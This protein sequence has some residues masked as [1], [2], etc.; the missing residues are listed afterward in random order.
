MPEFRV[1]SLSIV[2]QIKSNL[3]DRY[4]SG[5]PVLKEL[6]QNADDAGARR[7]RLDALAGWPNAANPLLR[8]PGLLVVNDGEFREDDE[9]GITSFGESGKV[10]DSA[11]I[12]KFG[13]GQ[14]AVFHLCD[15]F[16]VYAHGDNAP[17]ST[18]VNPFLGVDVD[19]NISRQWEPPSDGNLVDTDLTLLKQEISS[20]FP[21]RCLALWL[22]FRREGLR[23]APEAGFSSNFPSVSETIAE[24]ANPDDLRVLLTALRHLE[25]IEIREHGE[26]RCAIGLDDISE[27]LLGPKHWQSGTRSF[28][29]TIK[30][31]SDQSVAQFVG[32]ET[33]A[34]D[35][36]LAGLRQTPHWPKTISVLSPTPQ[37]EKGEPHGAATLLR[38]SEGTLSQLRISWAVFLPISEDY[39]TTIPLDGNSLGQFRLLLHGY[40]FLDSGRRQI[41]GLAASAQA[42]EP[43]DASGLR[44]A[45]NTELR[46]SVVLPL[47]PALLRD[48]L[49][50]K[51]VTSAELGQLVAAVAESLWFQENRNAICKESALVRVLEASSGVIWRL[52]P[53]E[54][55][56]RPLPASV[57][58]APRKVEELF[59]SI[60]SWAGAK[61]AHLV[62]D[63]NAAL[64]AEPMVW[65]ADDLGALFAGL[66]TRAFQSRDLARLLADF[67]GAA[68]LGDAESA[69]VGT[70]L[71]AALRKAMIEPQ[72]LAS[73]ELVKSIL[74]HVPPGTLFPLPA[75]VE[76]RRVLRALASA[77]TNIL[78]TRSELLDESLGPPL[79]SNEDLK[80]LLTALSPLVGGEDHSDQAATAALALLTQAGQSISEL[81]TDPGLASI[82]VLRARDV[83]INGPVVLS[84][85]MLVAQS[86]DGL[87]FANSP[88]ANSLLPLLADTIPDATPVV[89]EGKTAE[90]LRDS[91][92]SSVRLHGVG[93]ESILAL[94]N[95][96]K[97]YGTKD[98]RRKLLER[99]RPT[100][101]DDRAALRRLCVG[102]S[103]AGYNSAV[104]HVLEGVPKGLERVVEAI[105]NSNPNAFLVP[106]DIAD[107]L[108]P[109][110][111][112]HIGITAL[113]TSGMTA[114]LERDV[115]VIASVQLTSLER[116]AF[117]LAQFPDS[118]LRSL[119]IHVRSDGTMSTAEN[120][121]READWPIPEELRPHVLT[122]QPCTNRQ[123]R[124]RQERLIEAWSPR[125]QIEV[126]LACTDPHRFRGAILDALAKLEA[127]P[128]EQ[129]LKSLSA[130][131][132]L[133]A[134]EQP[135][136]PQ[137]VLALPPAVDEPARALLLKS[138][139][140]PPFLPIAKL[141]IDVREHRGFG[142]L[143]K[144][145]L[146]DR[147][148]SFE[149][150]ALMIEDAKIIGRLGAANDYP[151]DDFATLAND[152]GDL[153]LPGWP[154]LAAVLTS[155]GDSRD[156]VEKIVAG[157]AGLDTSNAKLAGTHLGSLAALAEEKGRKGEAARRAYRHGF[158]VV[159]GWPE[160]ARRQVFRE[161]RV[162]TEAGSWHSG[163]EVVQGGD[164]LDPRHILARDYASML[165]KREHTEF[166]DAEDVPPD[167]FAANRHRGEVKE[168]DLVALETDSADQQKSF[169]DTWR[170][171]I[172]S[173]LVIVYLGLIGR[174]EPFRR[175]ANEW[176][177][178]AT[179]D[180]DTLW[181]EL[182]S[183]FPKEILYPNPLSVEVDQRRFLIEPVA[184]ERVQVIAMS[185]DSFDA[186]LGGPDK[187]I[188]IGNLHRTHEGIRT[189]DG[190][191]RS[192]ITLPVRQIDPSG[193]SH[194]EAN[195]IFRR[196]VETIATD[197]LWLGM[198]RQQTAL[199]GMLDKAVE[200]D[201]STIEETERLLRDRL[202]TI[203]A[204][205]K[206]PTEY[207][208]QKALREYQ[209]E[210]SRLHHLSA[211]AQKMEELKTEL[212][213]KVS[214]DALAI[215]LLSA[216]R[217]KIG[218]FGYSSSRVLF[219]L[220]QNADDAYRQHDGAA[221]DA[222]FRV[223][224]FSENSGGIR[225]IHWGRPINHLGR[226]AEEG[227]RL[228]HDRDLL[229]MLLMNF[230]EKRPGDD[231]TGKFGLGFKS[232]HALTD[233]VGI[234]SG[235]IA[236]RTVGGFLPSAWPEGISAGED[237]KSASGRKATVIEVP[238]STETAARGAEAV[239]A[240]RSAV[241][242]LPA[243]ARTIRRIE[244]EGADP[245]SVSCDFSPLLEESAIYVVSVSGR[246]RERALRFDLS[247]GYS[248]LLRI[249]AAG[250]CA[251]PNDLRR[252]WN[253][254]PLEEELRSGWLINGPFAVDPGR[255]GLAGSITDRQEWFRKLG[256]T[257]GDRLLM[258][259]DLANANWPQFA[260]SLDLD[261][262]R[263]TAWDIFWSRLFDVLEPD[264]DD[265]LGRYLHADGHGYSYLA[266]RHQVVPT[267]LPTPFA[268]LVR[269]SEAEYY[270]DGALSDPAT[271]GK[272]RDWPTLTELQSGIIASEI[273][274]QLR[275]L[276]FGTPRPLR[277][278]SLLRRQIGEEWR[279]DPDLAQV[280]GRAVTPQSIREAPLDGELHDI[281]DIARQA[282]FLAQDG[283]WR[284]AQL[285][286]PDAADDAEERRLCAFAPTK[287][288]L[289]KRYTGAA[290]EF[291]RVARERSGFG[292]QARDL[293]SWVA[294]TSPE[295]HNRQTAALRYVI[296]GRQGRELGEEIRRNRPSWLP[297]PAS[298]LRN[299]QLLSSWTEKEKDDLL[300]ALQGRDAFQPLPLTPSPPAKPET[301]LSAIYE[302]WSSEGTDLRSL[303]SE[304]TYPSTFSPSQLRETQD[305]TAW[306]TMFA[307]A[308]FQSF[309]RT[310][311]G[312]HRSFIEAAH[313]DGW[314]PELAGSRPPGDVQSWLERLE[315]W[316]APELFDQRYLVWRRTFVDLYAIARWLDEYR[317]ITLKLPR[318]IEDYDVISLNDALQP[319]YWAPAMALCI[320][321]A[322]INRSLGIGMNWMIRE[323]LREGVYEPQDEA[324]M[325]PY[326]WAPSQRV[327]EL[328]N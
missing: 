77:P 158:S 143:E 325:A 297:W 7:F 59:D 287:H 319:S 259:H 38:A 165:G 88:Q 258:L 54:N 206:L 277:F 20:D 268:S 317:E 166:A 84:L 293:G 178:D 28:G 91:P 41:E 135:V 92:N 64:S 192:L 249:D 196:F 310:Q 27:R 313:R 43:S 81:A 180:V 110:L 225:A 237:R 322:P 48:A 281:L 134:D 126:A 236:L 218:D 102:D 326:C 25:S 274:G 32:R 9:R 199:Q 67:L 55:T 113:D 6:L 122:I 214:D 244:I 254:A 321:A 75:S 298:Q 184:G 169:L 291:F 142:H 197:C 82:E 221:M 87:L 248:L 174:S 312:Q 323:M 160:D 294:E 14:K 83:S 33:M 73:S 217:S 296:E 315:R 56:L 52:V 243:F 19:G 284:I 161:T 316:S 36:R 23:P 177:T 149:A 202:P 212:W 144:W 255:T 117:L 279:I 267:R 240:F 72:A 120:V 127:P 141:A 118:L 96:A 132:W 270:T 234:A 208:S 70:H 90:F 95:G 195:E 242:W 220:F 155:L 99:L 71:V 216:V 3:Q 167:P 308:C 53:S 1:S 213:R 226:D 328:L 235:F 145:V 115:N 300:Y 194:R 307:L 189:A 125:S 108:T 285:P 179:A 107:E 241:S 171:R 260:E 138:G 164:G 173:D 318:I 146:P 209:T 29:G 200:V 229:N 163:R 191:V 57:S 50:S 4:D 186:P 203:L 292:P 265:D 10:T 121:F 250:P 124:E 246:D 86:R 103:K 193:Y 93:N 256:R 15:A 49:N 269:A 245:V 51:M 116:D 74:A 21:D 97:S 172:P 247:D 79:L 230:S 98:A 290:L 109:R 223:E 128:D 306:F 62:V 311:D 140:T 61:G 47:L 112:Q 13:L 219:E 168:I 31:R 183:H 289:D 304:R 272:V 30:I 252:L 129:L 89:V 17:F 100:D 320:D 239:A 137:D 266:G 190:K 299:S 34:L 201:Q 305:R 175:L 130:K 42:E 170:G 233:S 211:P 283:T 198:E 176:A 80:A 69:V 282:L 58:D 111:R 106:A 210:E 105:L 215:E 156:D 76:N 275:K 11:A 301:V 153:D 232:V 224:L 271:L 45:W 44:R 181:A 150:L 205:L 39:D 68:I 185:G 16:V 18:V 152:G 35:G 85:E 303:Y 123:A 286:N 204:E 309:G 101:N 8:G 63:K 119:P 66:S 278:S 2:N 261:G 40:F 253:L 24:L 288:L 114:L 257:L 136:R 263:T 139:E 327:R 187:G 324:L 280:L 22:P 238:F 147:R 60:H 264:F 162:L 222:C 26:T 151:V 159:A 276:G 188:L 302:W 273:A 5:Y 295:D 37:P 262:S 207:R 314:W 154:L 65:S 227:R 133:F 228:G 78:P 94:V 251:F 131:P 231:L 46:D 148:S 104:L 182:D 12:G 157:F